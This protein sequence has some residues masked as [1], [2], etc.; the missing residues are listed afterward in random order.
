[1]A[2]ISAASHSNSVI[3]NAFQDNRQTEKVLL[4]QVQQDE[5][6]RDR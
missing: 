2:R 3:L 4:K 5:S 6:A 1:M